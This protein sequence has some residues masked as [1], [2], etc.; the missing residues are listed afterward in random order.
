MANTKSAKRR[1]RVN[2]RKRIRNKAAIS[3][4]KTLVK[5]V[6]SSTEKETAEQNLKEAVSFLDRTA[7]KGRIHKNN[8]ARKKAKLTK[9]VNAL[10]K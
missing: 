2:E 6:F 3:K 10:E 7:A 5:R 1:I 4:A 8:V 9:F